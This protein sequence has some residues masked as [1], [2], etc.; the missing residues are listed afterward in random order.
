MYGQAVN[1]YAPSFQH[2]FYNLQRFVQHS[3]SGT[4]AEAATRAKALI[5]SHISQQVY[6]QAIN[7]VFLSAAIIIIIGVV[8]IILI[9]LRKQK[10][11]RKLVMND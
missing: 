1:Q 8:P 5:G 4:S 3:V 11:A 6:V 9:R 7:D 2:V 10:V